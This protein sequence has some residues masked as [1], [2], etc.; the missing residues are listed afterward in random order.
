[1]GKGAKGEEQKKFFTDTL[2]KPYANGNDL[3]DAARQSIKREYKQLLNEFPDVAKMIE[4]RTPDGDFTYDQAIRVAMWNEEG[5]DIPGLSQRDSNKLTTL[6]NS[7]PE[8][9]AFKDALIVTGRQGR[10]WIK[11]EEYWDAN[12]IISDL[13]DITEGDGRKE[14]LS[15]FI[16]NANDIFTNENL[17][18]IQYIYGTNVR[19]QLE[20]SLYRMKNGK[21]RPEGTDALT[22]K[23]MNWI[24][25]ST[26]AIMFFNIRS[27][28]LQTISS[29]N[30]LN[31]NDNNP[32]AVATA[33][34]NQKQYWA[35]FATII[36]S[37]KMRERRS[38]LKAD[39]TQAEIANAANSTTDKARGILSYL[40][41]I[42]FT[43]TQAADSFS[44]AIGGTP[45]Y[46]NRT[47]TYQ[48]EVII[49]SN[50]NEVRKYTDAEAKKKAF[51]DFRAL[52]EE[53]QQSSRQD[54]VSNVQL[55]V[56]GRLIFAF[57]NRP[58]V[59]FTPVI[60]DINRGVY[61]VVSVIGYFSPFE[62]SIWF[63][64]FFT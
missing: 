63:L 11:P 2:L 52:S 15:E 39:V 25:G 13:H 61:F 19:N 51:D 28:I 6:V 36:N 56:L 29:T 60:T 53:H 34:A 14:W 31:W 7:D 3:M 8:L 45:F 47:K 58:R 46:M 10:G 55:G 23:W 48:K 62:N 33:F 27:A 16:E 22:N 32:L 17:N 40:Q 4:K 12:T 30:Y 38:G 42:G 54:R 64:S 5:V 59:N 44:I 26:A 41:K 1:M 9:K 49:D 18:K 50:G 37:D 20:D 43:P 21:S 35:D 57:N 24:N